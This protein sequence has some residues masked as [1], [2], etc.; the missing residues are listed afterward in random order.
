MLQ[1]RK[2]I[3]LIAAVVDQP[4]DEFRFDRRPGLFDWLA[5]HVLELTA[6]QI[7]HEILR[8]AHRLRQ[9]VEIGAVADEIRA[10]GDQHAHVLKTPAV[11]VEQ[12]LHE[13]SRLV[14]RFGLL[15]RRPAQAEAGKAEA[16]QFLEL[17]DDQKQRPA[18]ETA[19]LLERAL[20]AEAGPAQAILDPLA[21]TGRR[22]RAVI[23]G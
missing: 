23:S 8:R 15:Y 2:L 20:E 1:H 19:R 5:D 16:E 13:L 18:P 22:V 4:L 3:E 9:P 12:D 14:A 17:I 21:A 6:S 7:R 11:G 10:H